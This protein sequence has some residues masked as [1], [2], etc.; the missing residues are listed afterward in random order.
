[1]DWIEV[2]VPGVSGEVFFIGFL[3]KNG[4]WASE[5]IKLLARASIQFVF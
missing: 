1:M 3:A 2:V 4:F 5:W